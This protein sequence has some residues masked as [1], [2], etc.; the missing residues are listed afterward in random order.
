MKLLTVQKSAV[1]LIYRPKPKAMVIT[2]PSTQEIT[3]VE[4][5]FELQAQN[6]KL[7]APIPELD[8]VKDILQRNLPSRVNRFSRHISDPQSAENWLKIIL[9]SSAVISLRS[10]SGQLLNIAID[11]SGNLRLAQQQFELIQSAEFSAARREL[12]IDQHW[13]L[14]IPGFP[15]QL[16]KQG[17]LLDFLYEQ[18]SKNEQHSITEAIAFYG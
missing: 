10:T 8:S 13:F 12:G 11:C 16:P 2:A 4:Q 15:L 18:L 6:L 14:V 7:M 3:S 17:E 9:K 1:S 5:W